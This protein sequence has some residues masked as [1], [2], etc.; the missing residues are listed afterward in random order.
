[1]VNSTHSTCGTELVFKIWQARGRCIFPENLSNWPKAKKNWDKE[2]IFK[3]Y[4]S[5]GGTKLLQIK[6]WRNIYFQTVDIQIQ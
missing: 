1:M 4:K 2:K 3:N 6:K 5:H